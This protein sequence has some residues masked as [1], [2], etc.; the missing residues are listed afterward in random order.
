M[1]LLPMYDYLLYCYYCNVIV[2]IRYYYYT[3]HAAAGD[4]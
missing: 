3:K 4:E 1:T 2:A